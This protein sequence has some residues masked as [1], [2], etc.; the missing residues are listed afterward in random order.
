VLFSISVS[1]GSLV[2]LLQPFLQNHEGKKKPLKHDLI[3]KFLK[4]RDGR[5]NA[6]SEIV[7]EFNA[8]EQKIVEIE[9]NKITQVYNSE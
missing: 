9:E 3:V 4:I 6:I 7:G 1:T 5:L 8:L 2:S